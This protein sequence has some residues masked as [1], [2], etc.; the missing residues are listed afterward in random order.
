MNR[1]HSAFEQIRRTLYK[2]QRTMG[3]VEA[4][5]RGPDKLTERL[6]RRSI[7]RRTGRWLGRWGL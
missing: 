2:T 4:L 6:I 1:R 3:D 7:R 5:Q